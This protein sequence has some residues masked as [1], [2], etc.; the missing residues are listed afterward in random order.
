MFNILSICDNTSLDPIWTIVGWIINAIWIGIPIL[1]IILG[2]IDLAK[3]VITSKD[4][5]KKK[6]WKSLGTRFLYA[7]GVFAVVW[8]VTF[9]LGL[10]AKVDNGDINYNESWKA[11]W[12]KIKSSN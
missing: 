11:C 2:T 7:V 9:V 1:L 6:A 4:D 12:N 10:L 5:E 8:M 3:A